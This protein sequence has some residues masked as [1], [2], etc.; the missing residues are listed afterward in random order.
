[1]TRGLVTRF[2][3]C[4]WGFRRSLSRRERR[5]VLSIVA[6]R[7]RR[8]ATREEGARRVPAREAYALW[9]DSYVPW[10]HNPLM[11]AEQQVVAPIIASTSPMRALDVGTG[12]G[13]Y[14]PVLAAAGA[15]LAVGVDFSLPMLTRA[16]G[17]GGADASF[18]ED[19][20]GRA[21][22]EDALRQPTPARRARVCG[23]ARCLP[24]GDASFDVVC[25]SL[26]V[27][28]V[29]DLAGWV[30]EMARVLAPGGHLIYSDFH[31]TWATA[32]WRRTFQAADGSSIEVPYFSHTVA[33]HAARLEESRFDV[34][35]IREQGLILESPPGAADDRAPVVVVFHAVKR[36]TLSHDGTHPSPWG[37]RG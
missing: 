26:M 34:C 12:S 3:G 7:L 21:Q 11:H 1:M 13:R 28:D 10:P 18:P 37:R 8:W 33:E 14:L 9:A 35:L 31:P 4:V 29:A 27:G 36:R 19:D 16:S 6:A 23:D 32:G 2:N 5:D 20:A 30:G 22:A 15:R 25:A 17:P 24:F